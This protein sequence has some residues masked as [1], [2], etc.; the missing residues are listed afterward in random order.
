MT[1][2]A[3]AGS[4]RHTSWLASPP[5][6]AAVEVSSRHV[7][8]VAIAAQGPGSV[9]SGYAAEPLP[10]GALEPGLNAVNIHDLATLTAAIQAA[11][12]KISPRPRRIALVLPD[13]VAKVSLIRFEKVPAKAQDLDQ[14]IRWQVRKA[15]PFR[16]EDALVSWI[17]GLALDGG[18]REFIVS[19]AR[20]DLIA[21]YEQACEGAGAHAGVV[22]LASFNLIN[23]VLAATSSA[24]GDWLL[25]HI[26]ADYATLAVVR[27][28]DLVFFRNRGAAG[29]AEF[30][31]L[32][33][34]T[35]MYH[36][37]RLGAGRFSRVVLTG[38]ALRGPDQADWIR[39]SIEERLESKIESLDFRNAVPIRD[40]I[41]AGPEPLD[42]LAPALGILLRER[43]E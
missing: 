1:S 35:A 20:K 38:A 40:R 25:V 26:G 33:H 34:Q 8:A 41:G 12:D 15:A 23:T 17:P 43:V 29:P 6:S 28:Q 30:A 2:Q 31:D 14:L 22:D 5:P 37:D 24:T 11:L 42:A 13:T 16:I 9:I 3:Q 21:G 10:A 39:R 18:G 19:V 7:A 36:E 4:A 32:V 27:G